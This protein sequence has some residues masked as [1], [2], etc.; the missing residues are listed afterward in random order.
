MKKLSM[1]LMLIIFITSLSPIAESIPRQVDPATISEDS[2]VLDLLNAYSIISN[3]IGSLDFSSAEQNLTYIL[4]SSFPSTYMYIFQRG[5]ELLSNILD[6][7]NLTKLMISNATVLIQNNRFSD[8]DYLL[9]QALFTL[10]NANATYIQLLELY[11]SLPISSSRVTNTFNGIG[12]AINLLFEKILTLKEEIE[13]RQNL[14]PTKISINVS[15]LNVNW[16]EKVSI[17]GSLT[18]ESGNPLSDREVLIHI[19]AKI[20]TIYTNSSGQYNLDE[21][22]T[23]YQPCVQIYSEFIPSGN[24]KYIYAYSSSQIYNVTVSYIVPEVS[25]TLNSTYVTPGSTIELDVKSNYILEFNLTSNLWNLTFTN[26]KESRILLEVPATAKEGIYNL[27]VNSLPNGELAPTSWSTNLTVYKESLQ[28]NI[29]IPKQI[30]SGKTYEIRINSTIPFDIYV[31]ASPGINAIVQGNSIILRIPLSYINSKVVVNII[32]DPENPSYKE[33]YLEESIPSYN[34]LAIF[35]TLAGAFAVAIPLARSTSSVRK[36][37]NKKEKAEESS[38]GTNLRNKGIVGEFF[39]ALEMISKVKMEGWMT[40]RE[41]LSA[42]KERIDEKTYLLV[43]ELIF[44]I[45]KVIYGGVKYTQLKEEVS[46]K[47]KALIELLRKKK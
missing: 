12:S 24:D 41:Y 22:I 15:P 36:A 14:I 11:S 7:L 16:G 47:V 35:S 27:I 20:Y 44:K 40:L 10:A 38:S 45:E 28:L 18:E 23:S 3:S 21:K 30:F 1:F 25:I 13:N 34:S 4:Q 37:E 6:S 32:V 19:G 42:I 9:G 29:S 39:E 46:I 33:V 26:K 43:E 8:A 31:V 2:N 17:Q 5:N